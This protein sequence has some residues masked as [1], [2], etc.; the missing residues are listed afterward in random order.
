L[1][2]KFRYY[3]R[4]SACGY[5]VTIITDKEYVKKPDR[6]AKCRICRKRETEYYTDKSIGEIKNAKA[7]F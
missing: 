1:D 3:I 7:N 2:K 5:T 6:S 4:C